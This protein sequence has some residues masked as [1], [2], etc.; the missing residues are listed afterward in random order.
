MSNLSVFKFEALEVRAV[1]IDGAPWFVASDVCAA[2]GH[3]NTSKA[4]ADHVHDD[5]KSNHSLGLPGSAPTIVN[6]S[7]LYALIF[8]SRL[9][10]AQKFK[11]WV[12]SEVLP[13]IRK[14]GG[15]SEQNSLSMKA[16]EELELLN[17]AADYLRVAPSSRLQMIGGFMHSF[18]LLI[19]RICF[20]P[21]PWTHLQAP[22]KA[23][24][25]PQQ[26]QRLC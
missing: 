15:Y 14:T 19:W 2:L 22:P 17:M 12:T 4:V 3:T 26:P 8:G 7:G 16:K 20:Q 6:E 13:S 5:D 21:T 18:A 25:S 10:S 24:A 9:E 1:V 23:A 11:R